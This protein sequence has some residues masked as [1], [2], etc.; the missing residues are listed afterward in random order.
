MFEIGQGL[1]GLDV[2]AIDEHVR[3]KRHFRPQTMGLITMDGK[4]LGAF[5][6]RRASMDGVPID[7]VRFSALKNRVILKLSKHTYLSYKFSSLF[8]IIIVVNHAMNVVGQL[9]L[10]LNVFDAAS[11]NH[12]AHALRWAI[13]TRK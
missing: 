4:Q 5:A 2:T 1:V 9:M 12:I 3:H 7:L 10:V 8:G 11:V 13:L 6:R